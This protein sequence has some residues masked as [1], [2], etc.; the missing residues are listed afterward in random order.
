LGL[1]SGLVK[2]VEM[3]KSKFENDDRINAEKKEDENTQKIN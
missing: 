1:L 3:K 2:K